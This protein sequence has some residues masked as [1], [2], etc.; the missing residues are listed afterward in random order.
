MIFNY[1]SILKVEEEKVPGNARDFATEFSL[2]HVCLNTGYPGIPSI[3]GHFS[4]G[5]DD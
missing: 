3:Y 2:C 5:N 4:T 1:L